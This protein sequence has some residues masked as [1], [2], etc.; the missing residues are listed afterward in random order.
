MREDWEIK[1]LG[2]V[3]DVR[4]GTHDSPKYIDEGYPLITSKN[5]KE[6]VVTF[7]KVKFI[8]EKDYININKR[9]KVNVGDVLFAMIGTIGSPTVITEEPNYAIKNVALFKVDSSQSS[10]FL[11]YYLESK[12]VIDKMLK[13][14][15]GSTQRFVGLGYL[16][17]FEILIPPLPEQ[18]QIV[19]ILDQ[20]FTAID[21]AKAN[22][23][24]NIENATGLF[25]SKLNEVFRQKG[26]GWE[27][28]KL[29]EV[30]EGFQYGSSSKSLSEGVIPVLRMGNIQNGKIDWINLKYSDN[31]QENKKLLLIENDVLF[32]RTNS[33]ELVG[34]SAIYKGEMPAIFAGYLIR[35]RGKRNLLNN[36]FLNF[37]LNSAIALQYGY[38][39]MSSSVNQANINASKL[40]EYSIQIPDYKSQI[41]LV[42]ELQSIKNH[43]D[44]LIKSYSAKL[45]SLEELKK[46]FLQK[47]FAGELTGKELAVE[48]E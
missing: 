41:S 7:D 26:D 43:L 13:D 14:A 24:K 34:K 23:E 46:S 19:A 25:Q 29:R 32:N 18:K 9:S 6:G 3:Y 30:C 35:I 12:V 47:G 15:N 11:K 31:K 22:I 33:P 1:T 40:K 48:V 2:E 20:A 27:S 17:K 4:D 38:S 16:R 44:D 37:Y 8:S 28:K 21:Q 36:D 10:Q 5:L 42:K 45:E 39:V